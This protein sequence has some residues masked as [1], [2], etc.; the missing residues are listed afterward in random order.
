MGISEP[1]IQEILTK[2][3]K[4]SICMKGRNITDVSVITTVIEALG[5]RLA[6]HLSGNQVFTETDVVYA[7]NFVLDKYA[8]EY[9]DK[10]SYIVDNR[11]ESGLELFMIQ[12]DSWCIKVSTEVYIN[13]AR[14]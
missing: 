2:R 11:E 5:K 1:V 12:C 8:Q 13:L 4:E 7:I 10:L 9:R 6:D 3:F 14:R